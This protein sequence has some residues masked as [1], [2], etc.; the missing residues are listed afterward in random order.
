MPLSTLDD[1]AVAAL[2][3]NAP[4]YRSRTHV[5][6]RPVEADTVWTTGNGSELTAREGD[7]WVSDGDEEWSV[8]PDVFAATYTSDGDGRYR[9]TATV[10]AVQL[11]RPAIVSTLEGPAEA[12][13]GDWLV[14]NVTGEH[15]P[16]PQATFERRYELA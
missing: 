16:V 2:L 11:T 3:D 9:K 6:T 14:R 5:T 10:T 1:A 13:A 8:A 7:V 4:T 12:A 15:W